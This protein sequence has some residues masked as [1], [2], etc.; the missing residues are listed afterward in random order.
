MRVNGE[1]MHYASTA[2]PENGSYALGSRPMVISVYK[3]SRGCG[4][5]E[6]PM[7]MVAR[8]LE[9]KRPRFIR[10]ICTNGNVLHCGT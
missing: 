6:P 4:I 3:N 7:Q 2:C 5:D 9:S 8:S 10:R 1:R